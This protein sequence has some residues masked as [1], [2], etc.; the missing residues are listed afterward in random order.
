MREIGILGYGELGQQLEYFLIEKYGKECLCFHY[1]D[2][3]LYIKNVKNSYPFNEYKKIENRN[4][5]FF[6]CLGYKHLELKKHIIEE[7]LEKQFLVPSFIHQSAY[8]N[9]TAKIGDGVIIFPMCNIDFCVS[10]NKGVLLHNNVTISHHST[11]D[12]CC[13][14]APSVT[15]SGNV[16]V[17]KY[18]FIGTGSVVSNGIQ[19]GEKAQIGIGSVVTKDIPA[20]TSWIGNPIKMLNK[21]IVR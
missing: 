13:F 9:K 19:I 14:F 15:L 2:D 8:I 3:N 16:N 11:I 10:I 20:Q 7:L 5:N 6:V 21:L 4:I 17:K 1:F 18:S 12:E